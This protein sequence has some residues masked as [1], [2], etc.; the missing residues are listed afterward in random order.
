MSQNDSRRTKFSPTNYFKQ[1]RRAT[2]SFYLYMTFSLASVRSTILYSLVSQTIPYAA[3]YSCAK[4][5]IYGKDAE[6]HCAVHYSN[7]LYAR[8]AVWHV[9]A[10]SA[11][12]TIKFSRF[13]LE[14]NIYTAAWP[15]GITRFHLGGVTAN[16]SRFV[17]ENLRQ[18]GGNLPM[19]NPRP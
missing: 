13:V 8:H 1:K 10:S 7:S 9:A 2:L 4:H 3:W 17:V 6:W 5:I 19:K 15:N 12:V 11:G 16:L 14:I 18:E